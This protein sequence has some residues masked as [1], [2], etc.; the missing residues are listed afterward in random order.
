MR[1]GEKKIIFLI[2][3]INAEG[4]GWKKNYRKK[5]RQRKKTATIM[6]SCWMC[7]I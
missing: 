6:N 3:T 2:C 5:C 7:N 1:K 4:K